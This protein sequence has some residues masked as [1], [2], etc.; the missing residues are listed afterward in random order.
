MSANLS[1]FLKDK[2]TDYYKISSSPLSDTVEVRKFWIE[3][4]D[5]IN[6]K[7]NVLLNDTLQKDLMKSQLRPYLQALNDQLFD[8]LGLKLYSNINS[9]PFRSVHFYHH[10]TV[11]DSM[12]PFIRVLYVSP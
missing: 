4:K 9:D 8:N 5:E 6:I 12:N 11:A 3:A 10:S 2:N 7:T 1:L